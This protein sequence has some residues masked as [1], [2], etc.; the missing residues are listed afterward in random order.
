MIDDTIRQGPLAS[1]PPETP[2]VRLAGR[3]RVLALLGA[4]GMG[5]VYR[6]YDEELGEEVAVKMLLARSLSGSS[7][8]EAFRNEVRLARKVSHPNVA[9]IF[10]I[11]THDGTRFLTMELVIGESL[12][13]LLARERRLDRGRARAI[14]L[15]VIRGLGA[16]HAAGVVHRDLKPDNVLVAEGGAK[17]ADFGIAL[18]AGA[19][20]ADVVG[21][22]GYMPPEQATGGTVDAR[23]DLYAL[24]LVLLELFT[25]RRASS[26]GVSREELPAAGQAALAAVS[27]PLA[28]VVGR[29]L[30][31]DPA[32]RAIALDAIEHAVAQLD[33]TGPRA[34]SAKVELR[35][36]ARAPVVHV[37][38]FVAESGAPELAAALAAELVELLTV[39][40]RVVRSGPAV[41]PDS[42]VVVDGRVSR[43]P[44]LLH[45]SVQAQG[46]ADRVALYSRVISVPFASAVG[47]MEEIAAELGAVVAGGRPHGRRPLRRDAETVDL[48][49][50]GRAGVARYDVGERTVTALAEAARR[51]PD[52]PLVLATYAV[53]LSRLV[54]SALVPDEMEE[55]HAVIQRALALAPEMPEVQAAL[56]TVLFNANE[57]AGAARAF[58]SA[59]TMAPS[60]AEVHASI[61]ALLSECGRC[62]PAGESYALARRL[63]PDLAV[64]RLNEAIHAARGGDEAPAWAMLDALAAADGSVPLIPAMVFARAVIAAGAD[65]ERASRELDRRGPWGVKVARFLRRTITPAQRT[66]LLRPVH[67]LGRA[68][69]RRRIFASVLHLEVGLWL[70]EAIDADRALGAAV[71]LGLSDL[72]WLDRARL[73]EPLRSTEA[74]ARARAT[75]LD[76]VHLVERALGP[77]LFDERT[78]GG[79]GG[80]K[81]SF[82]P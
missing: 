54:H 26:L 76:R 43:E 71:D 67:D 9:R 80:E 48:Y 64:V 24:G 19:P 10:D 34:P 42:L 15:D 8:L 50:R 75:V 29:C 17:I 11:G 78:G 70:G 63:M 14:G 58:V 2:A 62:A 81:T 57:N 45:V 28:R 3:Y 73:L 27:E 6:A 12:R 41:G 82:G 30:A 47:A 1:A 38:P 53:A 37:L 44:D 56:G 61:G 20:V 65:P 79:G 33:A 40:D 46:A 49:L 13:R 35:P 60:N 22:P 36:D 51:A 18:E 25:G 23:A 59:L 16:I 39:G 68:H 77:V 52:D 74:F 32:R 55:A 5:S 31:P 4:G 69:V 72:G 21:T 7:E 66:E